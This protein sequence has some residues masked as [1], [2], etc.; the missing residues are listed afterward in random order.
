MSSEDYNDAKVEARWLAK[1]RDTVLRYLQDEG[2]RHRGVSSKPKWF[3]APCASVWAVE[4]MNTP[5]AVGWW[6]IS[7]DLPTDYLSGNDAVDARNALAAFAN[8]WREVS[9]YM[10][11]GERRPTINIGP[12]DKWR[13]LGDLL[14]RRAKIIKAWADD[15][16]MW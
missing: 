8:R 9:G 3:I 11:R 2:V 5:G 16:A 13:E 12:P 14:N 1:Q 7:G 15:D 6:A 4:S 10:L